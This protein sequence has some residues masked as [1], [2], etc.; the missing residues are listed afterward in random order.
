[1]QSIVK[2][3]QLESLRK[4]SHYFE[5]GGPNETDYESLYELLSDINKQKKN[6]SITI[7]DLEDFKS[8]WKIFLDERSMIGH[9]RMKPYGYAGD[10]HII[11]RFLTC[12]PEVPEYEKWDI[13]SFRCSAGA[14]L[15][16]RKDYFKSL[17]KEKKR[18][19]KKLK[20]LNL[21]SGPGR[22]MKE[23]FEECNC[24]NISITCVDIDCCAIDYA[25]N[26]IGESNPNVSFIHKNIFR[27]NTTEQYDVVWSAGMFDY[28]PDK[29]FIRVL[30]KFQN[31]IKPN[32][33]III[34]NFN[35]NCNPSRDYMELFGDWNLLHRT[36]EQLSKLAYEAGF[37]KEQICVKTEAENINLFLHL[38]WQ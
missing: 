35:E 14:T 16:N 27:F 32:G 18:T 30:K 12:K 33:E 25:Q 9:V 34:G 15:R 20:V 24:N 6:G 2:D 31:W 17:I 23:L 26:L 36:H 13:F 8:K 11:D 37:S 29:T 38:T 28:F 4:L 19:N 5:K 10:F 21:I 3:S 1:M 7:E 22:D